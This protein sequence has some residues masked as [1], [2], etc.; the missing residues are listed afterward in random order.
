M[1][2][3]FPSEKIF[4]S[5]GSLTIT[6]YA[7]LIM[8]GAFLAYFI[9]KRNMDKMKYPKEYASDIFIY[10]LWI[11][12]LGARLWF[13]IF[14]NFSYYISHPLEILAIWD[15]GLAIQGGFMAAIIFGYF[16]TKKKGLSFLRLG[17]A[18]VPNVLLAQAIGRWGNFINRECH[19]ALVDESYY[20][21][22]LSFL[23][24]G[25]LIN[26]N[27]Y[28]PMFFYESVLCLIGFFLI[29]FILKRHQ[30]KRGDLM[31][32]Y[33]MWYGMVRFIIESRRTD[34]LM[35]GP[36][37]MAQ[38]I[39]IIFIT[40]GILGFV[41]VF[42]KLFKKPK[43]TML[44]DLDGTILDTQNGII[45]SYKYVFN[46]HG[47]EFTKE[48]ETEVLG[49]SL[50][51]I[52][53]KYFSKEEAEDLAKEY[54]DHNKSI[55]KDA[56]KPMDGSVEL[57]KTLKDNGYHIGIVSTKNHD[58]V[59]WNLEVYDMLQYVDDIIGQDD[60]TNGK[61]SPEGIN[62]ILAKN[63]W[64]RDNMIYVG[65]S[66]GDINAGKNAGAY[67]IGYYFNPNKKDDLNNAMANSYTDNLLD[68][69]NLLKENI[70]F[71][72]NLS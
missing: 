46:K 15:G 1:I 61:P 34:A 18:I 43:P 29:T 64:F 37:K 60:V 27:Y 11:G 7:V 44:F 35:F 62:K 48:M 19:G 70:N 5:F 56:N 55:F 71:T 66:V 6:W 50:T 20:D 26:G 52:F 42:D 45:Q 9:S 40:I 54:R 33:F 2:K 67:T 36:L 68:I 51:S 22:I 21:G 69:L 72:S 24:D 41:G 30:N 14:Y 47:K 16:Y 12:I 4:V 39:S 53:T 10:V 13:C 28:E 8:T 58:V 32:S 23:K 65:D 38:V 63:G 57:L 3:F 49:P 59:K 31:W 17:D 25:M